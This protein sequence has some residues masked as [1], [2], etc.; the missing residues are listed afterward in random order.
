MEYIETDRYI[1]VR[2]KGYIVDA[3]KCHTLWKHDGWTLENAKEFY[4]E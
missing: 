3:R 4:G 1:T 2:P